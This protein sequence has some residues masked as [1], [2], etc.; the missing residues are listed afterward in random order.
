MVIH[1][2]AEDYL[3]AILILKERLGMVRSIDVVNEKHFKKPSVSVAMKKLRENGYIEMDREGFITLTDKGYEIASSVYNRHKLLTRF[4][5]ALGVNEQT[6]A[7]D[8]C[9]IEH[10]I[11]EETFQKILEHAKKYSCLLYTSDA[12]DD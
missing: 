2:S 5:V 1:E 3:E 6:A 11:S 9:K 10:D 4:F 8:A 7:A 12:A